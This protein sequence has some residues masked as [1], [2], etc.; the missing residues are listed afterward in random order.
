MVLE[1]FMFRL[2]PQLYRLGG[3]ADD[4]GPSMKTSVT[5][6][7]AGLLVT[8]SLACKDEG[9]RPP[10]LKQD[11]T[12]HNMSWTAKPIEG[13]GNLV[14]VEISNDTCAI[15][16]GGIYL[17]D[18]SGQWETNPYSVAEWNGF[19]WK[20]KHL[21]YLSGTDTIALSQIR[22]VASFSASDF[23]L[24]AGSIFHWDG[25]S[26]EAILEYSR[27]TLPDPNSTIEKLWG[28]SSSNLYGVG[29]VGTIVYF[30][31]TSWH[32]I[33]SGTTL[34]IHD[35]W[36][37]VDPVTGK[38]QILA[39]ASNDLEK[40]LL[41]INGMTVSFL[42]DSGLSSSLFGIWFVP[43]KKYYVVGGGIQ[44]KDRI[45][46]VVWSGYAPGLVTDYESSKVRGTGLNDVFI[47]GSFMEIV[48]FNGNSWYN[49][50]NEIP[51][52]S[53]AF[54]SVVVKGNLV[55]AVGYLGQQPMT[56]VGKR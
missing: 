48:H 16:V 30:D 9:T 15:A 54:A 43:E 10:R 41:S 27:L 17:K 14:D 12:S 36:G 25:S 46:D 4:I 6:L 13:S 53:G 28:S 50:R 37:A 31:G 5:S 21:H 7:I 40:R 35:I 20:L 22:G 55:I 19:D 2:S 47:V 1:L 23:W 24:A 44:Q 11:T 33:V 26:S 52:A 8:L 39:V 3:G 18:S 45:A 34:D 49:Y 32:N 29:N 38:T 56:I 51:I 42:P